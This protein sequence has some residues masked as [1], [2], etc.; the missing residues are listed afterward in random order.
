[1]EGRTEEATTAGGARR[2]GEAPPGRSPVACPFVRGRVDERPSVFVG[3]L[4]VALFLIEGQSCNFVTM[5]WHV[6][7]RVTMNV[8]EKQNSYIVQ[9][10]DAIYLL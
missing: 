1:V 6:K 5:Y 8:T 7:K 3:L 2:W 10:F 9:F 4:C